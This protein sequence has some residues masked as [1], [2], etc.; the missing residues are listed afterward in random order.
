M[1]TKCTTTF[2]DIPS[3]YKKL[4]LNP[5]FSH[6]SFSDISSKAIFGAKQYYKNGVITDGFNMHKIL[7]NTH[8]RNKCQ[9]EAIPGQ[10]ESK[11]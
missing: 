9:C 3:L 7:P 10:K 11:W 5:S 2:N 1:C 8:H 6:K 4:Y